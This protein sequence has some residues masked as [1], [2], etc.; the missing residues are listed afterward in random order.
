[1]VF[2]ANYMYITSFYLGQDF[3]SFRRYLT[4]ELI[5]FKLP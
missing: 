1:M 3:V 2:I 4:R 5:G